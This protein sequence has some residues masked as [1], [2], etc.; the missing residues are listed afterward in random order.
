MKGIVYIT[1][2]SENR[3][4][5]EYFEALGKKVEQGGYTPFIPHKSTNHGETEEREYEHNIEMLKKASLVIAYLG[6]PSF[7]VGMELQVAN[8]HQVPIVGFYPTGVEPKKM[9]LKLPMLKQTFEYRNELT[10]LQW[11]TCFMLDYAN[12]K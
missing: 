6:V 5:D 12:S 2:V 11:V 10:A 9:I 1:G 8:D 3:N 7:D 4:R